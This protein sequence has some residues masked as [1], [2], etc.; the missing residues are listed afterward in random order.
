MSTPVT[1]ATPKQQTREQIQ[2]VYTSWK[3]PS[4]LLDTPHNGRIIAEYMLKY[5]P[6]DWSHATLDR[7]VTHPEVAPKLMWEHRQSPSEIRETFDAWWQKLTQANPTLQMTTEVNMANRLKILT[8]V[9]KFYGSRIDFLTLDA[10]FEAI[11]DTL[12]YKA[13]PTAAELQAAAIQKA[14]DL[15]VADLV[16][17][18]KEAAENDPKAFEERRKA[19]EEADKTQKVLDK[20]EIYKM[21]VD[22]MINQF[23]VYAGPNRVHHGKTEK[24][25]ADLRK[26]RVWTDSSKTKVDWL[27]TAKMVR[28]AISNIDSD[29][30][31]LLDRRGI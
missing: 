7:V 28:E 15:E 1:P 30:S 13:P 17:R 3:R 8:H 21:N 5:F 16:R 26:I 14:Q 9:S 12:E 20:N 11:K 22:S 31:S 19:A 24:L 10:S 25:R 6:N 27:A 29:G 4:T 18:L 23:E 2:E